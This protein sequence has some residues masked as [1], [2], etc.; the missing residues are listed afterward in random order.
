MTC[1]ILGRGEPQ[2]LVS[3]EPNLNVLENAQ[4]SSSTELAMQKVLGQIFSDALDFANGQ[5]KIIYK[6]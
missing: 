6:R 5:H 4:L 1:T 3:E 2:F